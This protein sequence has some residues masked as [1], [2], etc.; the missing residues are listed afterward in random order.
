MKIFLKYIFKSINEKK[1]RTAL[2]ILIIS[3]NVALLIS[4][5][6]VTK[7]IVDKIKGGFG[8][9]NVVINKSNSTSPFLKEEDIDKS[10]F[11]DSINL[12]ETGGYLTQEVTMKV[13]VIE[14]DLEDYKKFDSIKILNED[15]ESSSLENKAI[16][17]LNT[18][19]SS[20]LKIGDEV[21]VTVYGEKYSYVIGA[22]AENTGIF[23]N[24]KENIFSIVIPQKNFVNIYGEDNSYTSIIAKVDLDNL[25]KWI[26]DFNNNHSNKEIEVSKIYDETSFNDQLNFS[27]IYYL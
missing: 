1:G 17:S 9:Y 12:L 16:I 15:K 22:I 26:S 4:T 14:M 11:E 5:L 13:K 27:D 10:D 20:N 19:K 8:S 25:N 3:I 6:G 18:S 24:D 23:L 21:N 7:S 2:L